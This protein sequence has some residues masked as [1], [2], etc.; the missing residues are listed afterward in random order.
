ML[1]R[2]FEGENELSKGSNVE[3]SELDSV[4]YFSAI[5]NSQTLETILV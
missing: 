3:N 1:S 4:S 5:T 2:Q